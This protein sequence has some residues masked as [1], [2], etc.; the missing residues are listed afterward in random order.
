[1]SQRRLNTTLNINEKETPVMIMAGWDRPLNGFFL[2]IIDE[3][4]EILFDN[5]LNYTET[6]DEQINLATSHLGVK[7]IN[8]PSDFVSMVK[9]DKDDPSLGPND[10][11]S[12]F[13]VHNDMD[14]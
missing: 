8:L 9:A 14:F 5:M 12:R 4:D 3:D 13:S 11:D 7:E 6:F 10:V 1:M 2:S